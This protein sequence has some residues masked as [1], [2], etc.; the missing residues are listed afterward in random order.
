MSNLTN[1]PNGLF[2]T[3]LIGGGLA[4]TFSGGK[5]LFVNGDS[6]SDANDGLSPDMP[7]LTIQSAVTAAGARGRVNVMAKAIAAGA[8]D[9]GSYAEN[10]VIPAGYSGLSIIGIS[11]GFTQGCL[12]Q[13]KVGATTTSPLLTV[14]AAG[15]SIVNM[16]I[17]GAGGTGGGIKL[18]GDSSTK[19]AFGFTAVN[20]YFKNC[21]SSGAALTGGAVYWTSSGCNWNTRFEGC[22]FY[23]CRAGIVVIGTGVSSPRSLVVKGCSFSASANTVVDC[24]IY[25]KGGGSGVVNVLIDSCQFATVDVPG[26]AT[27]PTAARYVDLTGSSG[28]MTNCTFGCTGKT[29]GAAG[30][31][32]F[33][34]TTVRMAKNYQENA[35]ITRT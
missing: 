7:K 28:A 22:E 11:N 23:D 20:C 35:I 14:R 30:D 31:A 25:T 26:Y 4:D 5:I 17:N 1:L 19:D 16:T 13:I 3:P 21:K 15:V 8:T 29:F 6:G 18:D 24:D 27:S 33:V 12:P 2:A 10:I 32:A 34:P 9:P